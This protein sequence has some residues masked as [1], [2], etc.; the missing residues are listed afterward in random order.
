MFADQF[1][2]DPFEIEPL[3]KRPGDVLAR[4]V[5]Q[6]I[7]MPSLSRDA[8]AMVQRHPWPGNHRQL[9]RLRRWMGGQDRPTLVPADLPA[10]WRAE[11]T[12]CNL[13]S[14]QAA[15]SDAIAAAL[16]Q[17]NGNKAVAAT[18]LGISRSS[19]YRKMR[20]YQLR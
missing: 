18:T 20:E 3:R 15:E 10:S 12:K 5:N 4:L 2:P 7:G 9:E 1:S 11:L 13:T 8:V 6:G 19:L 17:H 14:M 16:R